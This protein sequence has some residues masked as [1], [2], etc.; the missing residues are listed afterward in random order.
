MNALFSTKENIPSGN[1]LELL[2]LKEYQNKTIEEVVNVI[3]DKL[4]SSVKKDLNKDKNKTF[5]K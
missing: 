5:V 2:R 4:I 1:V 3:T